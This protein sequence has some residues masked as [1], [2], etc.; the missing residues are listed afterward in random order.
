MNK[1][2]SSFCL[3]TVAGLFARRDFGLAKRDFAAVGFDGSNLHFRRVLRHNDVGWDTAPSR[4]AG[5]RCAVVA[6]RLGNDSM[7]SLL[8]RKGKDG[9]G[10][11]AYLSDTLRLTFLLRALVTPYSRPGR[12]S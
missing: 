1:V 10:G 8:I 3:Y 6:A 2:S 7:P 5:Y 9:V 12:T 11:A 4:G